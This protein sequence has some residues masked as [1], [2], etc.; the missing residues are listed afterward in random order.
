[1]S[2]GGK[3]M[4]IGKRKK[5][6]VNGKGLKGKDEVKFDNLIVQYMQNGSNTGKKGVVK[7]LSG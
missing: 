5:E 3:S 4:K 7:Q 1:M 2:F 6:N